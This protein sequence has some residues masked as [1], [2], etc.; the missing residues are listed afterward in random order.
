[1]PLHVK[2]KLLCISKSKPL[3][4]FSTHPICR[5]TQ[6]HGRSFIQVLQIFKTSGYYPDLIPKGQAPG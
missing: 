3:L 4:T 2:H 5:Q 1:M 6:I